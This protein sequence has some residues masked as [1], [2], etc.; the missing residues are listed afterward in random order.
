MS[1]LVGV[2]ALVTGFGLLQLRNWARWVAVALAAV[3]LLAFP[4]GTII[5]ALVI[6]YMLSDKG[7]AAFEVED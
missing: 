3:S 1:G 2:V 4:V 6:W 7:K 5:G